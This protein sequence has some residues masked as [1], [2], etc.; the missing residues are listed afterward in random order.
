MSSLLA[1]SFPI[2]FEQ[3][4]WLWLLVLVPIVIVVSMRAL[5]ALEPLRR[6]AAISIRCAVIVLLTACLAEP[7]YVKISDKLT[8]LFLMD[9][10]DSVKG[11]QELQEEYIRGACDHNP[12]KDDLVGLI[13]FAA[14]PFLQQLPMKGYHIMPGRLPDMENR[15]RTDVAAAIR[16]ALA[17][18][19]DTAK[20]I[21]LLS[22][23]NDNMGDVLAEAATAQA[24]G[25]AIDVV[26]LWYE[27]GNEVYVDRMVAPT[28]VEDGDMVP[29]RMLLHSEKATSGRIDIYHNGKLVPMS[30][31][32]YARVNLQPGNNPFSVKI[33]VHGGGPQRF[34]ARFVADNPTRDDAI[35]GKQL[36]YGV[37]F[38]FR[39]KPS[40]TAE[41]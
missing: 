38:R 18:F 33:P 5:V 29:L 2:S 25:V 36:R 8:V 19:K 30:E 26:P 35:E 16:L 24:Q 22:D 7:M 41:Y 9:R 34:E 13:D 37:L 4:L 40:V 1:L 32:D 11:L 17:M 28:N 15:D 21:V 31:D 3:P 39:K 23:G 27:H 6:F 12:H 14:D 10:S 20:R